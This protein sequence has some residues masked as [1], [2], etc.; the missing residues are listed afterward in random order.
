LDY[1]TCTLRAM[2]HHRLV[3]SYRSVLDLVFD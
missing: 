2:V 3:L 1:V